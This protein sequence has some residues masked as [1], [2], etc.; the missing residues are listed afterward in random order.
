MSPHSD[1]VGI[2]VTAVELMPRVYP[3]L[4]VQEEE[5]VAVMVKLATPEIAGVP[6]NKPLDD[7]ESPDGRDPL[8][9]ANVYDDPTPPLAVT[10]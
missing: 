5:S 9:T 10:A 7:S 2:E 1:S 4:P 6:V 8:V 3:R